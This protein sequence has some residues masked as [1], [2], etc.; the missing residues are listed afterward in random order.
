MMHGLP[1]CLAAVEGLG[2]PDEIAP[3]RQGGSH[4][5][6]SGRRAAAARHSS[7]DDDE[8]GTLDAPPRRLGSEP[9][10]PSR[11]AMPAKV[12]RLG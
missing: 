11:L 10:E 8:G 2:R 5:R 7:A 4:R 6:A 12:T 9:S 1:G 3:V